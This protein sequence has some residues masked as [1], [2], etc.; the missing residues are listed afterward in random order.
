MG[1]K[2]IN[3]KNNND[4]IELSNIKKLFAKSKKTK[5]LYK[6]EPCNAWRYPLIN[7]KK[8]NFID[9][10]SIDYLLKEYYILKNEA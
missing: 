9:T 6:I 5:I 10:I 4:I 1:L 2:K 8:N 3:V 7:I